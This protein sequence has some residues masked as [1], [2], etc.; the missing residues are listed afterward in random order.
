MV[1]KSRVSPSSGDSPIRHMD[2]EISEPN[3][4]ATNL[5]IVLHSVPPRDPGESQLDFWVV[6][7]LI[8]NLPSATSN[9]SIP[10]FSPQN[11]QTS[12]G[13]TEPAP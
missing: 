1:Q 9:I 12:E 10:K 4:C 2:D 11:P 6:R 13:Q 8:W 7:N 5:L 3:D